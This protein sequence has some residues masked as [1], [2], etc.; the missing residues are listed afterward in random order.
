M[1]VSHRAAHNNIVILLVVFT[2]FIAISVVRNILHC[3]IFCHR[4]IDCNICHHQYIYCNIFCHQYILIGPNIPTRT[5]NVPII[6]TLKN[7]RAILSRCPDRTAGPKKSRT[8]FLVKRINLA[9]IRVQLLIKR[10]DVMTWHVILS[11]M[12]QLF[13]LQL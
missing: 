5:M 1:W 13:A 9:V 12:S 10:V 8:K 3:N 2:S 4:Y 6:G 11:H 7:Y